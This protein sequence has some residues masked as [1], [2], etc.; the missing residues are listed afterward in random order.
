MKI[1]IR[2]NTFETNSSSVHSL[3]ICTE[4]EFSAWKNG[5]LLYDP[6]AYRKNG[7]FIKNTLKLTEKQKEDAISL[8]REESKRFWKNWEDLSD[9]EK[10]GWYKD[11]ASEIGLKADDCY[12]YEEYMHGDYEPYYGSYKTKSG[13]VVVAFGRYGYDG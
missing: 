8:Y 13:E 12:T 11:Y 4:E 1:Q 10:E 5:E 9:E 3:C 6:Y 7:N 2:R